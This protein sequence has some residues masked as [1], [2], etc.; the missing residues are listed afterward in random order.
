MNDVT[1]LRSKM[2]HFP[3]SFFSMVMGLAGLTIAW[4][5][6]QHTFDVDLSINILLVSLTSSAFVL[7]LL[8]YIANYVTSYDAV[9][10]EFKSPVKLHFFPTVSISLLLISIAFLLFDQSRSL[11]IWLVGSIIYLLF[12]LYVLVV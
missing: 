3:L 2:A 7:F 11:A 5:K 10:K 9:L 1:N 4:H 6:A 12:T 8:L